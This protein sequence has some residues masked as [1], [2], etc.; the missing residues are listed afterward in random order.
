V[1][2]RVHRTPREGT[3]TSLPTGPA[4]RRGRRPG[5]GSRCS[6]RDQQ[7]A[8]LFWLGLLGAVR[9]GS[10]AASDAQ[11]LAATPE[12]NGR[13]MV[14]RVLS[15]LADARDGTTLVIDD[16]HE[17]TS[18]QALAQ[19]TR[20]LTSLPPTCTRCWRPVAISGWAASAPPGRRAGRDPRGR[21]VLH[22]GRD[23]RAPGCLGDRAVRC[24][25][26]AA[27]PANRG[28]GRGPAA[29]GDLT[30]WSPGSRAVRGRVLRQRPH[31]RRVSARRDAGP[32]VRRRPAAASAHLPARPGQR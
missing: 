11:P 12:F 8:Q 30:G 20:L 2:N 1:P 27:A 17:L 31:G 9:R 15:E 26:G 32:P 14:D 19:L 5:P 21:A 18:P 23:T 22:R 16:L 10:G 28:V 25:S 6:Q 24:W 7:D 29:G 13:A 4:R 3:T